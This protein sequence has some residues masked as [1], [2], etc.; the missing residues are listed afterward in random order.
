MYLFVKKNGGIVTL[1]GHA[2]FVADTREAAEAS[3][4]RVDELQGESCDIREMDDTNYFG[5]TFV[6]LPA[7]N[8]G[9]YGPAQKIRLAFFKPKMAEEFIRRNRLDMRSVTA[10]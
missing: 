1:L 7:K 9:F 4:P 6:K 3:L 5:L 8:A 10:A 2:M